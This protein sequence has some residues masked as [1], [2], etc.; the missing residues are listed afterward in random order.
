[1]KNVG[2]FGPSFALSNQEGQMIILDRLTSRFSAVVVYFFP[3]AGAPGCTKEAV[4]FRDLLPEFTARYIAVVG[5]TASPQGEVAAFG[6]E[7]G[8]TFD[9][10][11]DPTRR[12][13]EEWGAL[14][15]DNVARTTFIVNEKGIIT[16]HFPRV[17][18]FKHPAEV[19]ALFAGVAP[20]TAAAPAQAPAAAPAAAAATA[21]APAQAQPAAP[22][23]PGD[24]VVQAA[25][26]TLQLLVA[27]KAAGGGVPADVQ[28]LC[29]QLA[30]GTAR[31]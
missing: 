9:V 7:N 22:A 30:G 2:D 18:V 31:S 19:L 27:H 1:M 11:S 28:A 17:D 24:L 20:V 16:H 6:R 4:G 12:T 14:R 15:G 8:L 3:Q 21:V 10:L 29:A 5:V 26:A 13:C 23:T 25:R